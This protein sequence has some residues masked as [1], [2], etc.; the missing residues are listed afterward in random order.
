MTPKEFLERLAPCIERE[1]LDACVEEAARLAKEAGIDS[2][3]LLELS[4]EILIGGNFGLANVLALSAAEG[5][6]GTDKASAFSIAG[7]SAYYNGEKNCSEEHYKK[8]LEIDPNNADA[9][10]NYAILLIDLDRKNEAEEHYKKALEIKP[11]YGDAHYNYANL[12]VDLERKNEAEEHY[13]KALETKPDD[14]EA[15]YNYAILL[16]NLGRKSEAEEH[17]KKALEI[18]PDYADAH[19]NYAL[20]LIDLDRKN[21]AEEHYK[22]ALEIKP[23]DADAHNNYAN[24]LVDLERKNEAEEHYK[25]ALETKPDYANAHYNYAILL[26]NLGRKVE[27]EDQFL[28]AIR[29]EGKNPDFHYG[30]ANLLRDKGRFY[31]AKIEA[32]TALRIKPDS[33]EAL[34]TLGDILLDDGYLKEAELVYKESLENLA[35]KDS[36]PAI[37]SEI[38]NSLGYVYTQNERYS[39]AK[40]EFKEAVRLNPENKYSP[41]NLRH[42]SRVTSVPRTSRNQITIAVILSIFLIA[43]YILFWCHRITETVF[44]AQSTLLFILILAVLF[45]QH[46]SSF[47][48]GDVE[49]KTSEQGYASAKSVTAEMKRK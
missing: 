41:E 38:H 36:E 31:E 46:I 49:F 33:S 28:D 3:A 30:Y 7:L 10:N 47:K 44:A 2:R 21:E 13:K 35:S 19:N 8:A 18:K 48:V 39:E 43:S 14:S 24:L 17:Y 15:H 42:I 29:L 45:I 27:A 11:D 22:K 9:H 4:S 16:V 12:L 37:E 32:K 34:A 1:D 23:D 26:V 25:K 5:L 40:K 6:N 20:L